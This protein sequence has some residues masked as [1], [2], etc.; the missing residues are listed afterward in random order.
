M[1]HI[2]ESPDL[3]LIKIISHLYKGIKNRNHG[4]YTPVFNSISAFNIINSRI[5]VLKKFDS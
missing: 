5:A 1:S 4:F 2:I 3:I